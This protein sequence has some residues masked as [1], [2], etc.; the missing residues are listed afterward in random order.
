MSDFEEPALQASAADMS[1][2]S[3]RYDDVLEALELLYIQGN[4]SARIRFSQDWPI[5]AKHILGDELIAYDTDGADDLDRRAA[6]EEEAEQRRFEFLE[7]VQSIEEESAQNGVLNL[8]YVEGLV[9]GWGRDLAS[10]IYA[11]RIVSKFLG[12]SPKPVAADVEEEVSR[13]AASDQPETISDEIAG[14][15]KPNPVSEAPQMKT[16][17]LPK[18]ADMKFSEKLV[19]PGADSMSPPE[20]VQ[21]IDMSPP[22]NVQPID[23]AASPPV[24]DVPPAAEEVADKKPM[25]FQ[26][27]KT[28]ENPE[29]TE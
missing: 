5:L 10:L 15:Y 28:S 7:T 22:E 6:L 12:A 9:K 25:I 19:G 16:E 20:N 11:E 1:L 26:A 4:I 24:T 21:P 2:K 17:E 13:A 3:E 29:E 14:E 8:E 18:P 23:M 27:K